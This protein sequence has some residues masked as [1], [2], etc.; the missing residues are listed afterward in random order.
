VTVATGL[1]SPQFLAVAGNVPYVV[2][3]HGQVELARIDAGAETDMLAFADVLPTAL[4]S[5][6][7][8]VYVAIPSTRVGDIP[9]GSIV[10]LKVGE[11]VTTTLM[12][13]IDP[14]ALAVDGKN[15]Y[16]SDST[17]VYQEGIASAATP[18]QL[19]TDSYGWL[20]S[21]GTT[22]YGTSHSGN[23]LF[24]VSVGGGSY[25][26]R[27]QV[28]GESRVVASHYL[29]LDAQHVYAWWY[30]GI[31]TLH[32]EQMLKPGFRFLGEV[33]T[34]SL[35]SLTAPLVSDGKNVYFGKTGGLYR[36]SSTKAETP[37]LVAKVAGSITGL[38]LSNGALYWLDQG[39]S[40]SDGSL[41]RLV[42]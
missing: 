2:D 7:D 23:E 18:L 27:T 16:W 22:L 26:P 10:R 32:L 29:A 25:N 33:T 6:A 38:S 20:V 14:L 21:D 12:R 13:Q 41:H 34:S 9:D 8:N 17:G 24:S 40:D 31:S 39:A 42:L 1:G 4:T 36:V 30:D 19:T 37:T 28:V 35:D 11:S 15:F 5:D 3:V